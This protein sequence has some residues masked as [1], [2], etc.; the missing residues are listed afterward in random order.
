MTAPGATTRLFLLLGDPVEHSLS[1]RFQNAAIRAARIDAA[2]AALR[3]DA[4]SVPHLVRALCRGGGGGNVTVPHK[5]TAAQCIER[6]TDAVARTGACNTFWGDDGVVC[7]DNTDVAGFAETA[8]QLVTMQ[9]AT[10]LIVGAGGAAAAAVCALLDGGARSITLINRSPDRARTLAARLDRAGERVRIV[11]S[12]N[13]V[14]RKPFDLVVNATALGMRDDDP[15]PI[16]PATLG[17]VGAMLDLV[18]R[19]GAPTPWVRVA[20]RRRIPAADGTAMLL[21]QGA[22]A[23]ERWFGIPPDLDVMKESLVVQDPS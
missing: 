14:A 19:A 3:C 7:G 8:A 12:M 23:F 16:D 22:A 5:A 17:P 6:P 18:Y 20:R 10:S 2:Y 21:A 9:G 1:P 15:L 13:E 4:Q 11:T